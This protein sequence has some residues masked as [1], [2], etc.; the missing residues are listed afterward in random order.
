MKPTFGQIDRQGILPLAPSLDH[1]GPM[2]RSVA[3]LRVLYRVMR[4]PDA[5]ASQL[6]PFEWDGGK[7][8]GLIGYF[9]DF[10]RDPT[11]AP[12]HEVIEAAVETLAYGG[13]CVFRG[14]C[15]RWCH[16]EQLLTAHR[17]VLAAEARATHGS[18]KTLRGKYFSAEMQD[19]FFPPRLHELLEEGA[20]VSTTA[21]ARALALRTVPKLLSSEVL[22]FG[23]LVTPAAT[24]TAPDPST[25][26]DPCFNAPWSL[27]GLPT[28][29]FPI[30]L[31]A[32]GLPLGVQLIGKPGAELDL[33][34]MAEW[35]ESAIRASEGTG[36]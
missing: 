26:G 5:P 17:T 21:Y 9:W 24:G 12:M 34:R 32:D 28:V 36:T 4:D 13:L 2:A 15:S 31:S 23:A 14:T 1:V 16:P 18:P 33:L 29:S 25:T 8:K 3:D 35:C 7:K 11:L 6:E 10:L 20:K 27:L 30:G 19:W 22:R